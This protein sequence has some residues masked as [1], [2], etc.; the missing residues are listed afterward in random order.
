MV[1]TSRR[2]SAVEYENSDKHWY[3]NDLLHRL[4][5]PA[6]EAMVIKLGIKMVYFIV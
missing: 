1:K 4:E 2:L 3:I 5:G 6:Y